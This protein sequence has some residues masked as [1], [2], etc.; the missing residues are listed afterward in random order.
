MGSASGN[1][2]ICHQFF[3]AVYL[4]ILE[5]H[6]PNNSRACPMCPGT[7]KEPGKAKKHLLIHLNFR[8]YLC[9]GC[10]Y[11][12]NSASNLRN[13]L[14]KLHP[15]LV[16]DSFQEMHCLPCQKT[17]LSEIE[18]KAHL[19]MHGGS[20]PPMRKMKMTV[21]PR[22]IAE[23]KKKKKKKVPPPQPTNQRKGSTVARSSS[24]SA[25]SFKC[26]LCKKVVPS[27]FFHANAA[28]IVKGQT[29]CPFCLRKFACN[30][31]VRKHVVVHSGERPYPCKGCG[32]SF[33]HNGNLQ[34]HI[35][36]AHPGKKFRTLTCPTCPKTF[37]LNSTFL[38]HMQS[39]MR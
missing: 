12:C 25:K 35:Q 23:M 10:P 5:T 32:K 3:D 27:L 4:H 29:N 7:F 30:Q 13:H 21:I 6:F 16:N 15:E 9:P 24:S 20:A 1:C 8:P 17:M 37:D 18:Y 26:S 22:P 36:T 38:S 31:D 14:K 34:L 39:H 28:H 19:L 2:P 33:S 11:A